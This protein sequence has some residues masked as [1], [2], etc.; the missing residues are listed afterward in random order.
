MIAIEFDRH[1]PILGAAAVR[2]GFPAFFHAVIFAF[3]MVRPL[4]AGGAPPSGARFHVCE[5][6]RRKGAFIS[7]RLVLLPGLGGHHGFI[8]RLPWR[9]CQRTTAVRVVPCG[10]SPSSRWPRRVLNMMSVRPSARL[11]SSA[12]DDIVRRSSFMGV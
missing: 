2:P 11:L 5:F 9:S 6:L 3:L 8:Y 7:S 12:C 4:A 10:L 1:R